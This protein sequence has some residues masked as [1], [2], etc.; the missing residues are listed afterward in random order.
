MGVLATSLIVMAMMNVRCGSQGLTQGLFMKGG[1]DI[2]AAFP[3]VDLPNVTFS[4]H[5]YLA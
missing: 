2:P 4:D 3:L 1:G 5:A